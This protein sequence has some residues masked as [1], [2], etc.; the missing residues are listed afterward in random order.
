MS[1]VETDW[2]EKNL[3]HVKI[4]DSS[5]H[6]PQTK[7]NGFT[8]YKTRHIPN[9]I[10]FDLDD[11]SK[12]NI[13]LP[14][15]LVE[16]NNWEKIVSKMG[17]KKND[18]IIIYDNSD[19]ISS[20]RCWFNFIFFGH[21][22]K[23]VHILNGGFKKWT[24]EKRKTKIDLPNIQLSNYKS[25]EKKELVKNK[26]FIDRNIELQNFKVIDAR[27]KERFEGKVP[28]PRKGLRS[29]CIKNSFCIPFNLCLNDDKTFKDKE[30]LKDVFKSC[31][32]NINE[33]NI[34]F[35]C[36]SGVTACVLAL[37]YSL[38]NDKYQPCIYDGSWAEY[39]II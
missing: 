20:C 10:F 25:L 34:V 7:R 17:I 11:N 16:I 5:W 12:K 18:K 26:E 36:G 29:G 38:I 32:E 19:V 22:P 2:L 6:M 27:S 1:L 13:H 33:K 15:M 35:S 24:K 9:A 39:G 23:L 28:E 8:E 31:L 3:N 30:E 4:I 21:D 37:A 14:H